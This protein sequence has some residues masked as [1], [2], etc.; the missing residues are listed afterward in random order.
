MAQKNRI[1][2]FPA[3]ASLFL[4][5]LMG[6]LKLL[7][8]HSST[9]QNFVFV[10]S[11][12]VYFG[13]VFCWGIYI[14]RSILSLKIRRLMLTVV[15]FMIMYLVVGSAKHRVF[16]DGDFAGR[17]LWYMYYIPQIFAIYISFII[18]FRVGKKEEY[19]LPKVFNLLFVFASVLVLMYLTNDIHQLA[20]SFNLDFVAWDQQY[21]WGI[22]FYIS[23]A[24]IY[25]FLIAS[26]VLLS[27]KCRAIDK[28]K[29]LIPIFWLAVGSLY[30]F[31]DY[32]FDLWEI[33]PFNLPE[34]HCFILIAML[35]SSIR[36]GIM[37]SNR[38]YSE[39]VSKS[40]AA[41]QISDYENNVI[42]RS[43]NAVELSSEQM[44]MAKEKGIL[45]D[46]N[47]M[48]LSNSI[49]AGY[50]FWTEDMTV[51]NKMNEKLS[52][53]SQRLSEEG[54]LLR[55]ENEIREQ[56]A[57]VAEQTRLYDM[58]S[59]TVR[60]Q[61]EKISGLI[62]A[63]G[64]FDKNMAQI[65]ILNCYVKR[66][67]NLALLKYNSGIFSSE[68]LYLSLKESSEYIK[69]HGGIADIHAD[70][71]DLL[72]ADIILCCFDLWQRVVEMMLPEPCVVSAKMR[73]T[74]TDF[75]FRITAEAKNS[76]LLDDMLYGNV[77]ELGGALDIED[78]NGTVFITLKV[79]KGGEG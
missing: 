41:F 55:A 7:D 56:R 78:E 40:S 38:G 30:I 48:L 21:G 73:F 3:V 53:I 10:C 9:Y 50:V 72:D 22:L 66:R 42:Y 52:Q 58:I 74:D 5:L 24:W 19:K 76:S 45:I 37:P 33:A 15:A 61:L 44:N 51:V 26:V 32:I 65:C 59:E 62:V 2:Q 4:F 29:A 12:I 64:D 60:P 63:D 69:L 67:A 25:L 70:S 11:N 8:P 23:T 39:I 16:L 46:K 35:E 18:A 54:D 79:R 27:V 13:I 75:I 36:I 20:F 77:K 6:V 28:K 57:R 68:E 34:C 47:T 1:R 17:F 14:Q 49:P 71:Y 31:S 43:D